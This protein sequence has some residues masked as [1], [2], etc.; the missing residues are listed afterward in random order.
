MLHYVE[1][2]NKKE[3]KEVFQDMET[4]LNS[5]GGWLFWCEDAKMVIAIRPD[6]IHGKCNM[7]RVAIAYCREG[8]KFKRKVGG[9]IAMERLMW[10]G[11]W[12][13]IRREK[14]TSNYTIHNVMENIVE[15]LFA[16]FNS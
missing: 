4:E 5:Y 16:V 11:E 9:I 3:R 12:I 7:Y 13:K 14:P 1:L 6:A 10:N 15:D 8:D 2:M